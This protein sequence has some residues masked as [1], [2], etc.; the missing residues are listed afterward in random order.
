MFNL[1]K[2]AKIHLILWKI[3]LDFMKSQIFCQ[4]KNIFLDKNKYFF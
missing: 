2:I 3:L 4:E 1:L